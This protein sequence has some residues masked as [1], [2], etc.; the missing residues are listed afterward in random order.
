MRH[1][2]QISGEAFTRFIVEDCFGQAF[3]KLLITETL[4]HSLIQW[5]IVLYQTM[6][7]LF[8]L[9]EKQAEAMGSAIGGFTNC[10]M[11]EWCR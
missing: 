2:D 4:Y 1:L 8:A 11:M 9:D 10:A 3:L 6:I 7:H 5:S